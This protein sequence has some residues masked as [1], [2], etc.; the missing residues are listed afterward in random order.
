VED[1]IVFLERVEIVIKPSYKIL[2][3]EDALLWQ[4][5]DVHENFRM[6]KYKWRVFTLDSPFE[7]SEFFIRTDEVSIAE[8]M[9]N[10]ERLVSLKQPAIVFNR[11]MPRRI[12]PMFF[13]PLAQRWNGVEWAEEYDLDMDVP[14][15]GHK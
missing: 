12:S 7:G 4:A 1:G 8:A 15:R 3:E 9:A 14:W 5:R 11:R 2:L 10:V 6:F 13:N